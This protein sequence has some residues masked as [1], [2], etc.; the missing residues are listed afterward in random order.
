MGEQSK[1]LNS[2]CSE[3]PN[4][5]LFSEF[6]DSDN[7]EQRCGL[8][9]IPLHCNVITADLSK[10]LSEVLRGGV[11]RNQTFVLLA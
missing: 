4:E 5:Q 9:R 11:L 1:I 3:P 7:A 6:S 8:R 2:P 10:A